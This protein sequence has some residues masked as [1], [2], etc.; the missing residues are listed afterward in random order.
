MALTC[1]FLSAFLIGR[2]PDMQCSPSGQLAAHGGTTRPHRHADGEHGAQPTQR[3]TRNCISASSG[4]PGP[5][6]ARRGR[7]DH[8]CECIGS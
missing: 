7:S 4:R 6:P 3:A 5:R 8:R 2:R 1:M